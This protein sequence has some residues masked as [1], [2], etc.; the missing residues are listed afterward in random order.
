[1]DGTLELVF[2]NQAGS[3]VTLRVSNCREDLTVEDVKT[4]MQSIIDKN[5]FTST[6]GDLV[7]Y[8]GA[9]VVT[10]SVT[11]LELFA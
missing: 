2:V 5:I 3:K 11:E 10:R 8:A 9:R 7:G 6:G 1:M 4:V